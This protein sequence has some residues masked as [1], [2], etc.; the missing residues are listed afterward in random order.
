M[1]SQACLLIRDLPSYR[2]DSFASGLKSLGYEVSNRVRPGPGNVLVVWNRYGHYD[3]IA[4]TYE[5]AGATVL[6]AENGY[7]GRDWRDKHWYALARGNHNGAGKWFVG[8]SERW[9]NMHVSL[10]DWRTGGS[11]IVVLATRHIGPD[12][13]RE[14]NGWAAS[15]VHRHRHLCGLPVRMRAHPG[16]K[17]AVPL[18]YDL[19]NAAAVITWGSGAALRA[20]Q[21]GVPVFYGFPNWIGRDAACP[22]AA[23]VSEPVRGDR[24]PMFRKLAWAMWNTEELSTGEPFKCLLA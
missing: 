24:L 16:E 1:R 14:P 20:L 5:D 18:E 8:G 6:V 22:F 3:T 12:K 23:G 19:R 15:I 7:L 10:Q 2:R 17:P 11:E 9:D 21:M 4:R 13:V